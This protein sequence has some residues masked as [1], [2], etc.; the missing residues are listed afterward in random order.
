MS[1]ASVTSS[2]LYSASIV[3]KRSETSEISTD[4]ISLS[5]VSSDSATI[6]TK[7]GFKV[8]ENGFFSTDFNKAAGIPD[9][10]KIHKNQMAM[11]ETYTKAIGSND[12][13]V[14]ALGKVWSFFSK[15]AGNTLDIDGS[16]TVDQIKNMPY[17]F[18]SNGSLLDNPISIQRTE[19][20]AYEV[21]Q[22]SGKIQGL[23]NTNPDIL[24]KDAFDTG[25][26]GFFGGGY[27]GSDPD[28]LTGYKNLYKDF[29]ASVVPSS[30][31]EN[32][33]S[34]S[35]LFGLFSM[36]EMD[37]SAETHENIQNYYNFLKSGQDF[38]SYLTD[39]FGADYVTNLADGMNIHFDDPDMFDTLM[40]E[41]DRHTK[42]NYSSYLSGQSIAKDSILSKNDNNTPSSAY[43]TLK[44]AKLPTSG[45]LLNLG[46]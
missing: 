39:K 43:Q 3:K 25:Q 29:V 26:R 21:S 42:E 9:N 13:P 16:M 33:I 40:K 4:A 41:I 20:E 6:S 5:A 36:Q 30:E 10:I 7:W 35:E 28:A 17:S 19:T 46:V 34:V 32:E 14:T 38:Q 22:I 45:K 2:S 24:D 11:T 44:N 8:D 12:D 1:I 31:F 23:T 15:V 18:Q 37:V 27:A